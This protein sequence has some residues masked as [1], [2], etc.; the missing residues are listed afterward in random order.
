M[1][2]GQRAALNNMSEGKSVW[3]WVIFSAVT[4]APAGPWKFA[5]YQVETKPSIAALKLEIF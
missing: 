1:R 4:G 2:P 5:H 3:P